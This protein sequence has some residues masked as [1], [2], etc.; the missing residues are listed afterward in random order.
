[1]KTINFEYTRA[2]ADELVDAYN[3]LVESINGKY[4]EE[5]TDPFGKTTEWYIAYGRTYEILEPIMRLRMDIKLYD[6][7]DRKDEVEERIDKAV[8]SHAHMTDGKMNYIRFEGDEDRMDEDMSDLR[9]IV[10]WIDMMANMRE[11]EE[12]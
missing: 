2:E 1:M 8:V 3:S 4:T 12:A 11:E 6:P 7:E 5:L 10:K 9:R